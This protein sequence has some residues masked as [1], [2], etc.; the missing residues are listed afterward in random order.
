MK[1]I[2]CR[3]SK[4]N[5]LNQNCCLKKQ[6]QASTHRPRGECQTSLCDHLRFQT[7]TCKVNF[8]MWRTNEGPL[9]NLFLL[10]ITTNYFS[11]LPLCNYIK[12]TSLRSWCVAFLQVAQLL[13]CITS[14]YFGLA[15]TPTVKFFRNLNQHP[16]PPRWEEHLV[17]EMGV[18]SNWLREHSISAHGNISASTIALDL[19]APLSLTFT[20]LLKRRGIHPVKPKHKHVL[21]SSSSSLRCALKGRLCYVDYPRTMTQ[22]MP[23]NALNV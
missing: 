14:L 13:T 17:Q 1:L 6:H 19:P 11:I 9:F 2:R 10:L 18:T 3:F 5:I 21:I 8:H 22:C 23:L 16:P 12:A 7:Q 20:A 15:F 4:F